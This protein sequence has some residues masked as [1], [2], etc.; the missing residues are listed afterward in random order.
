MPYRYE[1]GIQTLNTAIQMGAAHLRMSP[2]SVNVKVKVDGHTAL[3]ETAL[4]TTE[5]RLPMWAYGSEFQVILEGTA[6]I[7]TIAIAPSMKD[8]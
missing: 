2:G 7:K 6:R 3:D 1:T 5:Y 4:V 8:L